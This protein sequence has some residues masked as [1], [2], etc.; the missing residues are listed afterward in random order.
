MKNDMKR[1][2]LE[3]LFLHMIQTTGSLNRSAPDVAGET[4]RDKTNA[5]QVGN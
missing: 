4:R 3:K 5:G 2:R 1:K